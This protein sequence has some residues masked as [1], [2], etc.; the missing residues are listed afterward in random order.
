MIN[1]FGCEFQHVNTLTKAGPLWGRLMDSWTTL[2][3]NTFSCVSYCTFL[4]IVNVLHEDIVCFALLSKFTVIQKHIVVQSYNALVVQK[5]GNLDLTVSHFMLHWGKSLLK[6]E[7]ALFIKDFNKFIS[8][9]FF[10]KEKHT[11]LRST[12]MY[13]TCRIYP[14]FFRLL[15]LFIWFSRPRWN[16]FQKVLCVFFF[17]LNSSWS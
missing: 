2:H 9:T 14:K 13:L 4:L 8:F 10:L 3:P 12:H 16:I 15:F 1:A 7:G 5:T 6:L 17:L 11:Q